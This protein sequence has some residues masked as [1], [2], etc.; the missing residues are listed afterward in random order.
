MSFPTLGGIV[1]PAPAVAQP[2]DRS[3]DD[4][5]VQVRTGGGKLR[6]QYMSTG[7]IYHLGFRFAT[8]AL[9][10]AVYAAIRTAL[11][12]GSY[13]TFTYDAW[14]SAAGGVQVLAE[15]SVATKATAQIINSDVHFTLTL[16]ESEPR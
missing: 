1:L 10:D 15:L 7:Y 16:T 3:I 13:L 2:L 11:A 6:T 5:S 4:R 9:Y 14:P 12:S 8:Q